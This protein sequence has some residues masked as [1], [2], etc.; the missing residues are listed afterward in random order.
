[1]PPLS[2]VCR[3]ISICPAILRCTTTMRSAEVGE[4]VE[5]CSAHSPRIEMPP[6]EAIALG[7]SQRVGEH[8]VRDAIQG[9]MEVLVAEPPSIQLSEHHQSPASA[10]QPDQGIRPSPLDSHFD[11]RPAVTRA[12]ATSVA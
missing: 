3:R 8:L 9:V 6:D 7:A 2:I 11:G 4:L 1:M 5:G 12:T 10:D